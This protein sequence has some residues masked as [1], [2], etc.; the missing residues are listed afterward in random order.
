MQVSA[1]KAISA[2]PAMPSNKPSHSVPCA[3]LALTT[4]TTSRGKNTRMQ[5]LVGVLGSFPAQG[6]QLR[7]E[8]GVHG[9]VEYCVGESHSGSTH[10]SCDKFDP[11][12]PWLVPKGMAKNLRR[13]RPGGK[14]LSIRAEPP[15]PPGLLM[16]L[17]HDSTSECRWPTLQPG[18]SSAVRTATDVQ[19]YQQMAS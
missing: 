1:L 5:E 10:D 19:Q 15:R 2:Q 8:G 17:P 16:S 7:W 6:L 4:H 18:S 13:T 14:P 3:V 12:R 9:W 11:G